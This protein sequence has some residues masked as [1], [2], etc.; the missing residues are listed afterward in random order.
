MKFML[1]MS[2]LLALGAGMHADRLSAQTMDEASANRQVQTELVNTAGKAI[3]KAVIMQAAHGVLIHLEASGLPPGWHALHVHEFGA[4]EAPDF[5][6]SG[7]HFN[8]TNREHGFDNPNGYHAGDLPNVY[9]GANGALSVELFT[10]QLTLDKGRPNSLLK[11]GG[12]ALVIHEGADDYRTNPAGG[13]GKR[14]ACGVI[15]AER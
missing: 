1:L 15:S 2:T 12:T 3:G 14:L 8:P 7:G 11:E 6:S 13:A 9:V 5:D 10:D 4:C